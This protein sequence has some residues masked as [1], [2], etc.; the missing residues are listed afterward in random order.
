M[1]TPND[2]NYP[3]DPQGSGA[4]QPEPM[5]NA[6]PADP[7]TQQ[8]SGQQPYGDAV[9]PAPPAYGAAPPAYAQAPAYGQAPQYA[10]PGY[11]QGGYAAPSYPKNWMGIVALV[12]SILGM[13]L[14]GVIFGHLG[15][16][17]AKKGEANN[18]G[19]SIAGLIIGYLGLLAAIIV[20]VVIIAGFVACGNDPSCSD[21]FFTTN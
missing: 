5:G 20:T 16:S 12:T 4:Y 3:Q 2:N 10:A 19:L 17:A 14:V 21:A 15:L 6:S 1:S 8:P 13:S 9:P 11:P 18:R 7:F